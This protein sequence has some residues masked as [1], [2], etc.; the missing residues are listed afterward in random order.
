MTNKLL[1]L[2]IP[3]NAVHQG[4]LNVKFFCSFKSLPINTFEDQYQTRAN[5]SVKH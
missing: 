5:N 1:K 4:K 2:L 3:I